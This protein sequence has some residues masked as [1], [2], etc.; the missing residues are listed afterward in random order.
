MPNIAIVPSATEMRR[1][2]ARGLTQQQIADAYEADTG[3]KCSRS[4]IGMAINRYGLKSSTPRPRY[5]DLI[6]WKVRPEHRGRLD[7]KYLHW[8]KRRREGKSL[9]PKQLTMLQNW[10][11]RL[12]EEK[13][14][15]MYNPD[16]DQGWWWVPRQ[17]D[18]VDLIRRP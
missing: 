5:D 8:E 15:V 10:L 14:V 18:D 1:Y 2:L 12:R 4:A 7:H 9:T 13:A 16:T 11:E 3:V 17:A 6:P